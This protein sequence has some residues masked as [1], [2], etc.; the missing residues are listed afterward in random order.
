[1]TY[2]KILNKKI[3]NLDNVFLLFGD[4]E[5]LINEFINNFVEKFADDEFKDF[6]LNFIDDEKEE[7]IS[8]LINSVNQLPFMSERR[9][10]VVKSNRIFT[11][12]FKKKEA[13]RMIEILGDF[14]ETSILLFKTTNNPDKR[15]KLYKGFKKVGQV[16]EFENLKYKALDKW[17][18]K[19]ASE[20]GKQINRQAIKLLEN[21][22]NDDLQRLDMELQKISTFLGDEDLITVQ[23]VKEIISKDRLL[24]ENIIFDFVD[25]IGEQNNEKALRLLNDMIADGQSE[26][27]LLM[28]IARQIRLILQSKVLYR[29]G[30]SAKQIASR[31]KQHPYPIKKCI[32]QGRNFSITNLETILEMLLESNVQLVTGQDKELELELLILKLKEIIK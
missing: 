15:T 27:G 19:R 25:A 24:K 20:L 31:L 10:I 23:K 6:N 11:N 14:P 29:E 3:I 9:I 17:I 4:E 7:F 26:I 1:M 30:N 21:T 22:F 13:E 12:K 32:K 28:M 18:K 5:Y 16:L 8:T 2:K